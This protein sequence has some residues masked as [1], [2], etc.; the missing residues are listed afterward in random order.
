[1]KLI[2]KNFKAFSADIPWTK[3]CYACVYYIDGDTM[4]DFCCTILS[5]ERPSFSGHMPCYDGHGTE[6]P[7]VMEKLRKPVKKL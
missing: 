6:L 4:Y 1:M 7:Q 2:F 3:P 5:H